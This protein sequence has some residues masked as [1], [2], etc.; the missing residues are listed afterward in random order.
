MLN[1]TLALGTHGNGL[2]LG[3]GGTGVGNIS[4]SLVHGYG[5]VTVQVSNANYVSDLHGPFANV[6]RSYSGFSMDAFSE[7]SDRGL[8]IG[9]GMTVGYG[10]GVGA[11]AGGSYTRVILHVQ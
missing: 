8:V 3:T 9:A 7:P 5:G 1:A 11:F 6:S 4:I 10:F 2:L